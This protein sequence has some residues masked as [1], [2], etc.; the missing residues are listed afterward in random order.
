MKLNEL[1]NVKNSR[2]ANIEKYES[3]V[4]VSES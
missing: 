4:D 1:S 3:P 2:P